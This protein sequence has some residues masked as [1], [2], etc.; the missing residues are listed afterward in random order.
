MHNVVYF[1]EGVLRFPHRGRRRDQR[2]D[3]PDFLHFAAQGVAELLTQGV[4]TVL[5]PGR[6]GCLCSAGWGGHMWESF[7]DWRL[8]ILSGSRCLCATQQ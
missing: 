2:P 8:D 4:Q 6:V 1:D 3:T 7:G 5:Q